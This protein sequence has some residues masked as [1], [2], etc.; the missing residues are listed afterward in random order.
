MLLPA[1]TG[2]METEGAFLQ[3]SFVRIA[4]LLPNQKEKLRHFSEETNHKNPH[5]IA[6]WL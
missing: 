3:L 5:K 4:A 1:L 6:M 2:F